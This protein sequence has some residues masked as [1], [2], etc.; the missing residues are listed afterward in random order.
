MALFEADVTSGTSFLDV[1]GIFGFRDSAYQVYLLLTPV[2][3][4]SSG[5]ISEAGGGGTL[6]S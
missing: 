5:P 1:T 6:G 4:A 3:I 2:G